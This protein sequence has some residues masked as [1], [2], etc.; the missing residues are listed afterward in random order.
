MSVKAL[1]QSAISAL[2][3]ARSVVMGFLIAPIGSVQ[4]SYYW[5]MNAF[6]QADRAVVPIACGL[7]QPDDANN[8]TINIAAGRCSIGGVVLA[9]AGGTVDLSAANNATSYVWIYNNSGAATIGH[10]TGGWPSSSTRHIKLAEVTL[11]AGLITQILDRRGEAILSDAPQMAQAATVA[12]NA[13]SISS[14]PTQAQV[15]S[16]QTTLNALIAA[17]KASGQM[18]S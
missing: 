14:T 12:A 3:N 11:S 6:L 13:T 2:A 10:A 17:Q 16:I 8:T 18:A 9:Y 7:V 4:P 5:L 15:Q 1:S